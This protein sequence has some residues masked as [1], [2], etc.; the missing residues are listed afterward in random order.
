MKI[1][2]NKK[3]LVNK[4]GIAQKAVGAKTTLD[5]LKNLLLEAS[6]GKLV[7]TG[8]DLETAI[9]ATMDVDVEIPGKIAIDSKLFGDI[10][11]KMP[12]ENINLELLEEEQ[13]LMITSGASNIKIAI[14]NISEFPEMPTVN[15]D[16]KFT[17]NSKIFKNMITETKIA[18]SQDQT[19]P[20]L[21][22]ELIEIEKDS[23]SVVA[24]DGYRLAVSKQSVET[25]IETPGK[26]I[27]PG[28]ALNDIS[29]IIG[30][31]NFDIEIGFGN[32][33]MCASFEDV[34]FMARLLVGDF[35]PYQNLIPKEHQTEVK[36]NR[37][38]FLDA[39]DRATIVAS[40]DR[41]SLVKLAITDEFIQAT[42]NSDI[43]ASAEQVEI[44]KTGESLNIAF[45][46]RYITEALKVISSEDIIIR[47]TSN[48]SP[49]IIHPMDDS[50][51]LYLL[52]PVRLSN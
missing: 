24:V 34:K 6:E 20:L 23:L 33:F 17:I 49:C 8:Y 41:N 44:E 27:V 22:G 52:L 16:S 14:G 21:M 43:G 25:G 50:D 48:I 12:E 46:S 30:S 36:V 29:S 40:N 18:I 10:A 45:N 19:K 4:I 11:R 26:I 42:T 9:I 31:D 3:I 5:A 47:Y 51:Y 15:E 35:I 37:S 28:K 13:K 32:N 39:I 7:I 1:V 38:K 2:C